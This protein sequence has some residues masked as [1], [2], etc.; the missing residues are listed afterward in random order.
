MQSPI[1]WLVLHIQVCHLLSTHLT[2]KHGDLSGCGD[3]QI[4]LDSGTT[5]G[6]SH[7][8]TQAMT[9]LLEA[10]AQLRQADVTRAR[11]CARTRGQAESA[12]DLLSRLRSSSAGFCLLSPELSYDLS[13]THPPLPFLHSAS[14]L[15]RSF[16]RIRLRPTAHPRHGSRLGRDDRVTY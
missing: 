2:S 5:A 8:N 15:C 13:R 1:S 9:R 3:Q 4:N 7:A 16:G 11:E 6:P 14:R 10:N 12:D